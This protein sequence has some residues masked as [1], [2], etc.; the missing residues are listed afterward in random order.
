[1]EENSFV[2]PV[3]LPWRDEG[4]DYLRFIII[5]II[6]MIIISKTVIIIIQIL[7]LVVPGPPWR[8]RD[9]GQPLDKGQGR[10]NHL[11]IHG[12]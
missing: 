10:S 4:E 8:W 7:V 12:S 9:G 6:L 1:M 5:I 11:D 2:G 3:C